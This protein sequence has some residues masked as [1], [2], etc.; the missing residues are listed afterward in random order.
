MPLFNPVKS[1]NRLQPH[2]HCFVDLIRNGLVLL[3]IS[4]Y[5]LIELKT[6]PPTVSFDKILIIVSIQNFMH[7][8]ISYSLLNLKNIH[9]FQ[10]GS[11]ENILNTPHNDYNHLI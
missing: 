2:P 9:S 5:R 7:N 8:S 4:T 3:I 10:I 11:V 1:V 6:I